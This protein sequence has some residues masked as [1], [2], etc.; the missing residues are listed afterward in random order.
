MEVAGRAGG[1]QFVADVEGEAVGPLLLMG[2]IGANAVGRARAGVAVAAG[3]VGD[4]R[5][6]LSR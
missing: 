4:Q 2:G 3:L 5:D 1:V 6:P